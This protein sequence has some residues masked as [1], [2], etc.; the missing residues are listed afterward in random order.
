MFCRGRTFIASNGR[1][2][3]LT[4]NARY[5]DTVEALDVVSG[6]Y[7]RVDTRTLETLH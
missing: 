3:V 4:H 5:G 2:V 6:D 7:V 1:E